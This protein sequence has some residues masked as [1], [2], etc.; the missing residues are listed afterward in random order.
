[1]NK[2]KV[3]QLDISREVYNT[4]NRVGHSKA[5]ELFP[6]WKLRMDLQIGNRNKLTDDEISY[7]KPVCIIHCKNVNNVFHIGNVGPENQ[8]DRLAQMHSVSVGDV[9]VDN[10]NNQAYIVQPWHLAKINFK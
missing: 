5:F 6:E 10:Q 4:V 8:I 9:I 7:F 1:M 3:Y 2:F